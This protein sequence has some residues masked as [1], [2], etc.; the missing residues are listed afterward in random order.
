MPPLPHDRVSW[1]ARLLLRVRLRLLL[2]CL[3][4]A[5]LCDRPLD[6]SSAALL[7][8]CV[9]LPFLLLCLL[10]AACLLPTGLLAQ[11]RCNGRT[12]YCTRRYADVRLVGAHNSPFVG[13]LPQH[14]QEIS[15]TKQLDLGI[16]FLQGQTRVH[17]EKKTLNMCHTSCFLEDAGPVEDFLSTIKT[18]LDGH[19]EE[20]VTL[21][22]T[23][24]D[25]VDVNRF[26]E[27]F[28]KS[29]IKKYVFVPPS[30]PDA[31]PMDSWPM[32][33]NLISSGKRLI[34]FLDY[35]ADM[36]KFPYILDQFAYFFETP[37]STTDPKFPQC[38]IDRPPNAKADGRLYLVNHTLNVDIFG[39]IVPDRIRAPKTNAATGEGSIGAHV[40]LCNSIYDRKPN[41]VLLDFINQGEVFRAQNRMN[42]F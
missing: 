21:L 37:F 1:D 22:L 15:V 7:A 42:G 26:D 13:Y 20:V 27:A 17:E 10:T 31:L 41:V 34:V 2:P 3:S 23:N 32:L 19:P 4:L 28:T 5:C 36:P 39:V 8:V 35:K 18:W 33:G 29:G 16:R 9:L 6:S 11:T 40:D 30:S 14:N 24:G 38:K 25:Y 12:E